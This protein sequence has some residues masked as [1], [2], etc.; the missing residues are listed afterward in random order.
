M[1]ETIRI[2]PVDQT[3]WS[4]TLLGFQ[5]DQIK[6]LLAVQSTGGEVV[7]N[8]CETVDGKYYINGQPT[9]EYGNLQAAAGALF[10][11]RES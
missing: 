7:G 9:V 5:A 11:T 3:Q 10:K 8:I 4:Q 1:E 2:R 6:Q